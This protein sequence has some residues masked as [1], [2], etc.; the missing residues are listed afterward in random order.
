MAGVAIVSVALAWAFGTARASPDA[1]EPDAC[2][3]KPGPIRTVARIIDGETV[4]LD[5]GREVRLIGALAPRARDAGA[6]P[7][8]WPL[9]EAAKTTLAELTL[10]KTVE[11]AYGTAS[12][13][14]YG[15]ELAH[16]FAQ[17]ET[18]RRIWVQGEMLQLGFARAYALPGDDACLTTLI[19][20]EAIGRTVGAG[21]WTSPIYRVREAGTAKAL[22]AARSSFQIV[23]G[24]VTS[25][26]QSK[27]TTYLNFG[28]DWREDFTVAVP[29]TV[30]R[31]DPARATELQN[32]TGKSVE[33]RGWIERRNGP[34]IRLTSLA[35]LK[36]LDADD[37]QNENRDGEARGGGPSVT[38][39][40]AEAG[41]PATANAPTPAET[42]PT[43]DN[44]PK[45]RAPGDVDL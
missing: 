6:E 14:R 18:G 25:V 26:S 11:L 31:S 15:R 28:A 10:G 22:R 43:K 24:T 1:T 30:L 42:G 8:A 16:L 2:A 29:R 4:G 45:P 27:S 40:P 39:G 38:A 32:L 3:L 36:V 21:I 9:E 19:A 37:V 35:S 44:R 23:R 7:D 12:S 34:A 17:D 33:V 20:N 13:D 41:A 5:D